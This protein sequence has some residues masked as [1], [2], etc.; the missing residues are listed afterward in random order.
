MKRMIWL[1][2][3]VVLALAGC[4]DD[5]VTP[6]ADV[7]ESV[8]GTWYPSRITGWTVSAFGKKATYDKAYLTFGDEEWQAGD[9]CNEQRGTYHLEADGTFEMTSGASTEIGCANVPHVD[10]MESSTPAAGGGPDVGVLRPRPLAGR[11]RPLHAHRQ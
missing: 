9:G 5:P 6:G 10:V 8:R 7:R 2:A 11:D 4:G 3:C 1:G